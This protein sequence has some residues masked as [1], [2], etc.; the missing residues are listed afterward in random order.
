M[1]NR[2]NIADLERIYTELMGAYILI[3]CPNSMKM[4]MKK[5]VKKNENN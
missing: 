3:G 2:D 5:K 4:M 1:E